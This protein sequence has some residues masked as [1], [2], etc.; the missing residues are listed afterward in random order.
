MDS[1][2]RAK[3]AAVATTAA[4]VIIFAC[5]GPGGQSCD[6]PGDRKSEGGKSYTCTRMPGRDGP[7]WKRTT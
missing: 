6:R 4:A 3:V 7:E 2:V 1:A 5:A